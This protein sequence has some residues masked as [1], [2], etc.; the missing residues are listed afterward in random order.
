MPRT[1]VDIEAPLLKEIRRLQKEQGL[2]M[3]R[4]VSKLLAEALS[5]RRSR[6]PDP[7]FQWISRPMNPLVD[8]SDKEAV[9]AV[10]DRDDE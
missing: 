10:L 4:V 5:R 1:T 7:E 9:Y 3:G 6:T 2:S 8:V